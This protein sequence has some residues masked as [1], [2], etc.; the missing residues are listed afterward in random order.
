MQCARYDRRIESCAQKVLLTCEVPVHVHGVR[1]PALS[2]DRC[3][4]GFLL[5]I[6]EHQRFAAE[7][8]EVLLEYAA[9]EQRGHPRIERVSTLQQ[10]S[11][12]PAVSAVTCEHPLKGHHCGR[13]VIMWLILPA[14]RW[15]SEKALRDQ[16]GTNSVCAND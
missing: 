1:R 8:V 5:R 10:D 7:T 14:P 11:E 15:R 12:R 16:G 2:D 9:G 3:D 13:N 6:H 4:F